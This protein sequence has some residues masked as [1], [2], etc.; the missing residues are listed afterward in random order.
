MT[1]GRCSHGEV[2]T[3]HMKRYAGCRRSLNLVVYTLFTLLV[4]VQSAVRLRV[5][6]LAHGHQFFLD[7]QP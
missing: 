7:L 2:N 3:R 4:I 6:C 1:A 5:G